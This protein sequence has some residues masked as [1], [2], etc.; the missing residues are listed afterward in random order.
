MAWPKNVTNS[1]L[2]L[3]SGWDSMVLLLSPV[4]LGWFGV[5]GFFAMFVFVIA[6]GR[7]DGRLVRDTGRGLFR[8]FAKLW[9]I[10]SSW[11]CP[12]KLNF[13][14]FCRH[15]YRQNAKRLLEIARQVIYIVIINATSLPY[16]QPSTVAN[17]LQFLPISQTYRRLNTLLYFRWPLLL[18]DSENFVQIQSF[19]TRFF[20]LSRSCLPL[21]HRLLQRWGQ[22]KSHETYFVVPN[23]SVF[24]TQGTTSVFGVESESVKTPA[25][26]FSF[27]WWIGMESLIGPSLLNA[28]RLT[29]KKDSGPSDIWVTILT[30]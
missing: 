27:D 1:F 25:S 24:I 23:S 21:G 17:T 13:S 18:V 14:F 30:Y 12:F 26:C 5:V 8:I 9:H 6:F 11:I 2:V 22:Q 4:S 3:S 28:F 19:S 7:F 15:Q 29:S 20:F 10:F 16:R